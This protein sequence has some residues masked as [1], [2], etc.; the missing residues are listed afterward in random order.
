MFDSS[1]CSPI[2]HGDKS[3]CMS[4][5]LLKKIARI[6]NKYNK[7]G[8]K[9][10]TKST[11]KKL[12]KD[13]TSVIKDISNC[14][15]ERCWITIHIIQSELSDKDKEFINNGNM[16]KNLFENV[17][18]YEKLSFRRRVIIDSEN[19]RYDYYDLPDNI[20]KLYEVIYG[21]LSE[22]GAE[23]VSSYILNNLVE[24]LFQNLDLIIQA[25]KEIGE[26][27]DR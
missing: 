11:K 27:I 21:V 17:E 3:T 10:K 13:I 26:E 1:H 4:L 20:I 14:S 22:F 12:H 2:S 19:D 18:L 16:Y 5:K 9:I 7:G 8:R 25:K 24:T 15:N 23:H 6:L